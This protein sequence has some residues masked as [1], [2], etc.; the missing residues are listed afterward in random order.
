MNPQIQFMKA[1]GV[2]AEMCSFTLSDNTALF[3]FDSLKSV[4]HEQAILAIQE[5]MQTRKAT[6]RFPSIADIRNIVRP[7][8]SSKGNASDIAHQLIAAISKL[9]RYAK[10]EVVDLEIGEVGAEVVR[11]MGGWPR[12]VEMT[13]EGDI[14]IFRA[15]LRDLIEVVQ[16]KSRAGILH[17]KTKL[18]QP[19]S[20]SLELANVIPALPK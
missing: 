7:E 15:Q 13:D 10:K 20:K 6:D 2:L 5:L 9:G 18:A 11:R 19:I 16:Q 17:E 1:L 14:A 12:F 3:Y 8:I 4:G